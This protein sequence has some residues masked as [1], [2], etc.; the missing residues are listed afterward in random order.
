MTLKT[1]ITANGLGNKFSR[2]NP[3]VLP[4]I[5]GS[6]EG[7]APPGASANALYRS[8]TSVAYKTGV[9]NV[10]FDYF[11]FTSPISYFSPSGQLITQQHAILRA[12]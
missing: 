5:G 7:S 1:G 9:Y 8:S 10:D 12:F 3:Q 2:K 4:E 6:I 11:Q